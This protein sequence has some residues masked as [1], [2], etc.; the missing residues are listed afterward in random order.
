MLTHYLFVTK[1]LLYSGQFF[2][3]RMWLLQDFYKIELKSF[4]SVIWHIYD[5]VSGSV[6]SRFTVDGD[7]YKFS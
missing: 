6:P 7:R 4:V 5:R 2:I 1:T 3:K